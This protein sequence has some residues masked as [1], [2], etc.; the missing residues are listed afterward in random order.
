MYLTM[1]RSKNKNDIQIRRML[2]KIR[3]ISESASND[4]S[5][6]E[7]PI[8]KNT[9]NFGDVRTAQEEA[10]IKTIGQS[11]EFPENALVYKPDTKD[12]VLSGKIT[13]SNI[14]FQFRFKDPSGEG[15]YIWVQELQLT[16][17]NL[18]TVGEIRNAFLNWKSSLIQNGDLLKKLEQVTKK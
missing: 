16:D 5:T 11:V 6:K 1:I 10:V 14:V 17:A 7:F 13:A 4:N 12:L 3:L 15:C 8:T 9:K 18:E 2:D